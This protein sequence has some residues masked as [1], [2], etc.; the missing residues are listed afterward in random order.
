[1]Q[2]IEVHPD[3][4]DKKAQLVQQK[5]QELE[6]M[7]REL[8]KSIYY[9]QMEWSGVTRENFFAEFIQMK[10]VF[11]ATLKHLEEMQKDLTSTSMLFRTTDESGNSF[12]R[13]PGLEH[14]FRKGFLDKFFGEQLIGLG[15]TTKAFINNP[16]GTVSDIAYAMTIGKV[17]DAGRGIKFAWDAAWGNGTARSEVEQ[18]VAEQKKQMDEEGVRYYSG[19]MTGQVVAYFIFGKA[20][21]KA[22]SKHSDLG[23]SGGGK[24]E[25]GG[26]L[27]SSKQLGL[28]E[29]QQKKI[30][31]YIGVNSD[32]LISSGLANEETLKKILKNLKEG[33]KPGKEG[34]KLEADTAK[35]LLENKIK[36]SEAGKAYNVKE[37]GGRIGEIDLGTSRYIIECFNATG[38]K[39]K[40]VS[41]FNKYFEGDVRQ[42]FINPERKEII[43]YA[44]NGI[45]AIK[46]DNISS[47]GV[48]VITSPEEL[49]TTLKGEK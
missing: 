4:L 2:L 16:S 41:D 15:H 37:L 47:I 9:L 21:R 35:L 44:P 20:L 17:V 42:P 8:E 12:V 18:I 25:L 22:E 30:S 31:E 33:S 49:I 19:S 24:A 11:P 6:R 27:K 5:R 36:I 39:S 23:G 29:I 26:N 46:A 14:N 32:E 40:S 48:R 1:M 10:E 38:G 28:T 13:L 45:D 7:V 34:F 43:L 3:L